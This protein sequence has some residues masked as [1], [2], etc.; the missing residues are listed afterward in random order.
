LKNII[1][2]NEE[3]KKL[4]KIFNSNEAEF[5]AIYSHFGEKKL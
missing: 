4:L 5:L 2:R 3:K 1:G